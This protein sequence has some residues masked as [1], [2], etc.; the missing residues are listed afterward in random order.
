MC[1]WGRLRGSELGRVKEGGG[2]SD[3]VLAEHD[4]AG[5]HMRDL[6]GMHMRAAFGYNLCAWHSV[7]MAGFGQLQ[8]RF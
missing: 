2:C 3:M 1:M 4:L 8:S 7:G 6:A 5:M